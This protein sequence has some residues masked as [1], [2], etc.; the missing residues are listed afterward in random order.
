M[1]DE[2]TPPERDDSIEAFVAKASLFARWATKTGAEIARKLPGADA[3]GAELQQLERTVLSELRRKLD[4]VDPLAD[5][6]QPAP[7][8][9]ENPARAAN[10]PP[11]PKQTEPL[12]VA[13]AELL[14][15]SIEQTKQRAREYLYLTV[16]RQLLPDEA[17]ILAALADGS[18]YP[19]VHVDLRTGVTASR[20]LLA[21]ASTVGR[22]AGVAVP[23]SVPHYLT[24]LLHLEL[25][26]VG[27]NDLT[28][29]V[30]YDICLTD[31]KVRE[32]EKTARATGRAKIVRQTVRISPFGRE[33]WD[34]SHPHVEESW[35][36]PAPAST[37]GTPPPEP[38]FTD[39]PIDVTARPGETDSQ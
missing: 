18:T 30:Q 11:P 29:S 10:P 31:E 22:A 3:V 23:A 38:P 13:M 4:N 16:L 20:R 19:L 36:E 15:R 12:R 6:R 34:A 35:A 2:T 37:N 26:E 5:G 33:L 32:A 25:V 21:N 7:E 24:R 27:D 39:P 1:T 17:R 28:L 9:V 14:V 8:P